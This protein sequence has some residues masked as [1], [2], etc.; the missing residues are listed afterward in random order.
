MN[1]LELIQNLAETVA[2]A[3]E[4]Y[5]E[6]EAACIRDFE[7]SEFDFSKLRWSDVV[8]ENCRFTGC[9]FR[10]SEF[11]NVVFKK[12]D[13][14]NSN[15]SDSYFHKIDFTG[16]KAVGAYFIDC[17]VEEVKIIGSNF[18]FVNFTKT[19]FKSCTFN[20]TDMHEGVLSDCSLKTF[21]FD[22]VKLYKADFYKTMLK[23]IDLRTCDISGIVV[24]DTLQELKGAVVELIQ[25]AELAKKIGIIIK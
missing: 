10:K 1:E 17:V 19:K 20:E 5:N 12:C 22:T 13:L 14:S 11:V 3:K 25:A 8:F 6:I 21:A 24:S 4:E 16:V 23:G 18:S 2:K 7:L 15:F 9:D